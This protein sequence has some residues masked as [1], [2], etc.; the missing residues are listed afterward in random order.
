LTISQE[1]KYLFKQLLSR[2]AS[3]ALIH[4][5]LRVGRVVSVGR[6]DGYDGVYIFTVADSRDERRCGVAGVEDFE[7]GSS[8]PRYWFAVT[9]EWDSW[10][11]WDSWDLFTVVSEVP[12]VPDVPCLFL[13]MMLRLI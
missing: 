9:A 10:N 3:R 4:P 1:S 2:Q 12:K 11:L 8:R 13:A 6:T 7:V 5:F